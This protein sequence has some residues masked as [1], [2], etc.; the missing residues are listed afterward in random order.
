MGYVH[1][2]GYFIVPVAPEWRHLTSGE[3]SA[4]EHR[5]V[6]AKLLGRCLYPDESVHHRNGNRLDNRERN[7]ELWSRWQPRG[8]RVEDK[9]AYAVELLERYAPDLLTE[10]ATTR[11]LASE[12]NP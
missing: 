8:Q 1:H 9:V 2:T 6:M 5:L 7:L 12:L 10:D 3:T 11:R 4:P